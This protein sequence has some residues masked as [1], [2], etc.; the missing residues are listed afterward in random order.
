MFSMG[1]ILLPLLVIGGWLYYV[2][3]H[4]VP[5]EKAPDVKVATSHHPAEYHQSVADMSDDEFKAFVAK[6]DPHDP[7]PVQKDTMYH[8]S[9]AQLAVL[10]ATMD[11]GGS[12]SKGSAQKVLNSGNATYTGAVDDSGSGSVQVASSS[13]S[14][15]P[16]GYHL[17]KAHTTKKGTHVKAHLAK[18]RTSK[19]KATSTAVKKTTTSTASKDWSKPLVSRSQDVQQRTQISHENF[20]NANV[21]S[22]DPT[23]II[24]T[25]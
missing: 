13:P 1:K 21:S 9:P 12:T 24:G 8:Y 16:T 2:H 15:V 6:Q 18:N 17:V 11:G 4:D 20:P 10:K 22:A 25:H 7:K 19:K 3:S 5:I 14:T 23:I